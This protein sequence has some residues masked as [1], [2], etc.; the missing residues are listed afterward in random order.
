MA[1]FPKHASGSKLWMNASFID[2]LHIRK[3][4]GRDMHLGYN[5]QG[6]HCVRGMGDSPSWMNDMLSVAQ[7]GWM[8]LETKLVGKII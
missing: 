2:S 8:I 1:L 3:H 5:T 6:K 7:F 4:Y